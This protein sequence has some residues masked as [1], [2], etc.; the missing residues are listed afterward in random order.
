MATLMIRKL[1]DDIK[2]DLRVRAAK[3]GRS[4]EDE[5]RRTLIASVRSDQAKPRKNMFEMIY[6]ASRPGFDLPEVPD[7]PASFATFD[8]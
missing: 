8:E 4:L 1:P 5:A 7:S 3:N 2:Q 6:E